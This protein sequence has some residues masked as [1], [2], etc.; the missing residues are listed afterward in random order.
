MAAWNAG[1]AAALTQLL[2]DDVR[3]AMPPAALWFAGRAA[4]EQLLALFPMRY[5]GEHRLVAAAANRQLAAQR[6]CDRDVLLERWR[7]CS[8][9]AI[10]SAAIPPALAPA[11]LPGGP[12]TGL[13]TQPTLPAMITTELS[14]SPIALQCVE[15]VV[16]ASL[17]T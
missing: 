5:H 16:A 7:C 8:S 3:W 13:H 15:H 17:G 4:V 2:R 14:A 9:S 11:P 12:E 6:G 10:I 1:D